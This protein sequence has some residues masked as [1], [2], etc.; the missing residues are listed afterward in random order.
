MKKKFFSLQSQ[1][2]YTITELMIA[3]VAFA[4]LLLLLSY[5]VISFS[6]RYYRGVNNALT[7]GTARSVIDIISQSIQLGSSGVTPT[8]SSRNYFCAGGYFFIY[9]N[10]GVM[11]TGNTATQTG[12]YMT[13]MLSNV[14]ASP[15]I[16]PTTNGKQLLAERIRIST[17]NVTST[18]L[19]NTY[20]VDLVLAYG[21][22]DLLCAPISQSSS[23]DDGAATLLN[24]QLAKA[25]DVQCKLTRGNQFCATAKLSSAVQR[26]V[27]K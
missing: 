3:S 14:C 17:L 2:G 9:N 26:R 16:I 10:Q 24:G 4:S 1:A 13:P 5:G 22:N 23:C 19:P 12:L 15:P 18:A 20:A 21:D 11:F 7:Q 25:P 8:D 6:S 27:V